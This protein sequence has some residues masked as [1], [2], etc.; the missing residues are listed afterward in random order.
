MTATTDSAAAGV[1]ADGVGQVSD[2]SLNNELRLIREPRFLIQ[3]SPQPVLVR[4][5]QAF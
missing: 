3:V 4:V 2:E 5:D 1:I